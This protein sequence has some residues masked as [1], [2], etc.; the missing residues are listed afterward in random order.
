L[1]TT[2][3]LRLAADGRLS[4]DAPIGS[5]V[6]GV[7]DGDRITVRMLANH[8]SGLFDPIRIPSFRAAI[9]AAPGAMMTREQIFAASFGHNAQGQ[10]GRYDY[11]N[12]N[13]E[14]LAGVLEQVEGKSIDEIVREQVLLPL[15]ATRTGIGVPLC[16][17][18]PRGYRFGERERV[19]EYGRVFFDA[20][21]FSPSWAGAAGDAVS[22]LDD[23][24]RLAEPLASGALVDASLRDLLWRDVRDADEDTDEGYG[25]GLTRF[26]YAWGHA[27][28]VPGFSAFFAHDP[29]TSTT[30]V[31]LAN[32]SNTAE[33]ESPARVLGIVALETAQTHVHS[34]LEERDQAM[35]DAV[36]EVADRSGIAGVSLA[37]VR[38]GRFSFAGAH[39]VA[40]VEDARAMSATTPIRAGSVS[41]LVTSLLAVILTEGGRVELDG[42]L[43]LS[44]VTNPWPERDITLAHLLEHT[45]GLE[46]LGYADYRSQ[47]DPP[48]VTATPRTIRWPPGYFH[49][50]SSFGASYAAER[51]E[52]AT[53]HD[54]D[55]LME[56]HVLGPL[57]MD[58]STF[59]HDRMAANEAAESYQ[60]NGERVEPW[61]PAVRPAGGLISPV[62]DLAQVVELL[63]SRGKHRG[64]Q[65]LSESS[66]RRMEEP[67][68]SAAARAGL[69]EGGYALGL[70]DFIA[71]DRVLAGH[72]GR[73][74]GFHVTLGYD[75]ETGD[76]FVLAINSDRRAVLE[77][78]HEVIVSHLDLAPRELAEVEAREEAPLPPVSGW[79]RPFTHRI[80][81]RGWLLGLFGARRVDVGPEDLELS[82]LLPG[83]GRRFLRSGA[84][85]RAEDSP[86]A[87]LIFARGPEGET[88]LIEGDA[89][90]P[91]GALALFSELV[92]V[93]GSV[94]LAVLVLLELAIRGIAALVRRKHPW[95]EN[96]RG[97]LVARL[98]LVLWLLVLVTYAGFAFGPPNTAAV[99]GAPGWVAVSLLVASILGPIV[100]VG[101]L[102]LTVPSEHRA[103][104]AIAVGLVA[105]SSWGIFAVHGWV[106]LVTF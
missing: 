24:E 40:S 100:A 39:G 78:M 12:I 8:T 14:L 101:S 70:F 25:F 88:I 5:I 19:I 22:T 32:L 26:G 69:R 97:Q 58:R 18:H 104:G 29:T 80:P 31:A 105:V 83:S 43:E 57:R 28:D 15:G 42:P 79:Y 87:T 63:A 92:A 20:T 48:P 65:V 91:A 34:A 6:P 55:S 36:A 86:V 66:V 74:D 77:E 72:W 75:R 68:T 7:P 90:R 1:V 21:D 103:P 99:L 44:R 64:R 37:I 56:Q 10:L 62:T 61:R 51:L 50:Y 2:A 33:G 94:V 13:T 81:Q 85:Y 54:F 46:D 84:A 76:G 11:A 38:A 53:G 27:G 16:D 106:P 67:R 89:Y 35:L 96:N 41:K 4:L 47:V 71:G 17:H 82:T 60:A 95:K 102:A 23:L 30:V 93:L 59:R 98:A 9:N 52:A 49:A 73:I 45:A 3:A